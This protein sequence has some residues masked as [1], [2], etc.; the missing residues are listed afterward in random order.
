MKHLRKKNSEILLDETG[1]DPEDDGLYMNSAGDYFPAGIY[2]DYGEP[3]LN[4]FFSREI[5]FTRFSPYEMLYLAITDHESER[6]INRFIRMGIKRAKDEY[7][8][9]KEAA[10]PAELIEI[11]KNRPDI[12]NNLK[13]IDRIL[14]Y[15]EG[16]S[17]ILYELKRDNNDR[18]FWIAAKAIFLSGADCSAEVIDAIENGCMRAYPLSV[19][20]L[21]LGFYDNKTALNC[22]WKYYH[23]L[24][25]F[26]PDRTLCEGPLFGL[27]AAHNSK[28]NP[29]KKLAI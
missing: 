16:L 2:C 13:L 7:R 18:F 1:V 9:I 11:M 26:F 10:T 14:S 22:V 19:M 28:K 4:M 20:C 15:D 23:L 25:D 24:K 12:L 21:L 27:V 8:A 3:D 6:R 17:M 29:G 5:R